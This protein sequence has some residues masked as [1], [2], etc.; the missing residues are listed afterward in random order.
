[1][2]GNDPL[3]VSML[4]LH[5]ISMMLSNAIN[6]IKN[7][8]SSTDILRIVLAEPIQSLYVAADKTRLFEILA[9][10]LINGRR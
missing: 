10:L 2:W 1:M 3:T 4:T 8:I 5:N 9:N 6:E 7:K